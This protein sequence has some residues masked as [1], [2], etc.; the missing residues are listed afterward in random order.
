MK[1]EV[2]LYADSPAD[3]DPRSPELNLAAAAGRIRDGASVRL[4]PTQNNFWRL[5]RAARFAASLTGRKVQHQSFSPQKYGPISAPF[6][7]YLQSLRAAVAE[8]G[9]RVDDP[10]PGLTKLLAAYDEAYSPP[11]QPNLLRLLGSLSDGCFIGPHTF[12]LDIANTCNTNCIFCGL[13]SPLL[14]DPKRPTRGRRFTEGWKT[15]RL[16][17]NVFED[18]IADLA[19]IGTKED[20]LFSGEGEPLTHPDI[21]EMIRLVRGRGLALTVFSNGL[22]LDETTA[23]VFVENDLNILY[24]S[25]SAATPATFAK[26]QPAQ[27][28]DK[29]APM[30]RQMADLNAKKRK[31][32][33]KPYVIQAHV[34]NRLNAHE[35]EAAMDL[36]IAT[37][38]DAVRYQVMHQCGVGMGDLLITPEQYKDVVKQVDRARLK[39]EKHGIEIVA[40]IDFQLDRVGRTFELPSD[41]APFHWSHDL[42]SKTGCLAG[43]FF[44]RSFTDGRV[45]FC[46]HDKIVGSLFRGRFKDLWFSERY[47]KLRQAAKAFDPAVNP[48]LSDE[49]CGG[50]LLGPDCDFCGNYEFINQALS[51][52]DRL[53]LRALLRREP[54]SWP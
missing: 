51:D 4:V 41:V 27:G 44:S 17:L 31:K 14:V 7:E 49:S 30:V 15:K 40:N 45:S 23:D 8:I 53:D 35:C 5:E 54:P 13:H 42:Y 24:W 12:H 26:L 18:L 2:V 47:R 29:F 46:C 28:P 39:A 25:L 48:D 33:H 11:T 34:I 16:D 3:H 10:D 19:E 50:P 22:A 20:I 1:P 6:H 43:W 36:A 21:F 38:V 37:G 9:L 52:L 32:N